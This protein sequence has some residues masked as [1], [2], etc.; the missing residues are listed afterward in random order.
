MLDSS[1]YNDLIGLNVVSSLGLAAFL[2]RTCGHVG[3]TEIYEM[4]LIEDLCTRSHILS[5]IEETQSR[6]T[7]NNYSVFCSERIIYVVR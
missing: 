6:R 1:M 4:S 3:C 2:E 5:P 7:L